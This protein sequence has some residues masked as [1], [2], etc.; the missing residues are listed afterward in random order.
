MRHINKTVRRAPWKLYVEESW[1]DSRQEQAIYFFKA[2]KPAMGPNQPPFNEYLGLL[3][4][5]KTVGM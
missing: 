5:S 2:S 4:G 1:F 3:P